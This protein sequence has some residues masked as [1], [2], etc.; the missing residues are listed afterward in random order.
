MKGGERTMKVKCK[1]NWKYARPSGSF[2]DYNEFYC[3]KCC[4]VK[5]VENGRNITYKEGAKEHD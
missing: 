1:H 4:K 5:S 2:G 3:T